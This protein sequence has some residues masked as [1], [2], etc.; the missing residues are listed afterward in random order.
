MT[1]GS[2]VCGWSFAAASSSKAEEEEERILG[3]IP[4]GGWICALPSL[5]L[6]LLVVL[7]LIHE[8]VRSKK[9]FPP[10]ALI[11][12]ISL[13]ISSESGRVLFSSSSFFS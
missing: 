13:P 2:L 3:G 10:H 9:S 6:R 11:V 8:H 4:E 12:L 1:Y 5:P 7:L